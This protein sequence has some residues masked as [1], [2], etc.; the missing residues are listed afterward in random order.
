MCG[1]RITTKMR[2][3][4][5]IKTMSSSECVAISR[6]IF[7][8]IDVDYT[9]SSGCCYIIAVMHDGINAKIFFYFKLN[10]VYF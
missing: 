5:L 1:K 2:N 10:F 6:N 3:K 8:V 4:I 7:D 9:S